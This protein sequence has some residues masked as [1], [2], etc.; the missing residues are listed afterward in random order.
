MSQAIKRCREGDV[1]AARQMIAEKCDENVE[2]DG[3]SPLSVEIEKG[4]RQLVSLLLDAE[5]TLQRPFTTLLQL[6]IASGS[7]DVAE[8]FISQVTEVTIREIIDAACGGHRSLVTLLLSKFT[9]QGGA[10]ILRLLPQVTNFDENPRHKA[11]VDLIVEECVAQVN[12]PDSDDWT[13]LQRAA[14]IGNAY[15]VSALIRTGADVN[16]AGGEVHHSALMIASQNG[17]LAVV[18]ALLDVGPALQIDARDAHGSTALHAAVEVSSLPVVEALLEARADVNA[19]NNENITPLF[20]ASSAAIA[21]ALLDAG[22]DANHRGKLGFAPVFATNS[23]R[24]V[25]ALANERDDVSAMMEIGETASVR[26]ADARN[27]ELPRLLPAIPAAASLLKEQG[28]ALSIA[29]QE[30]DPSF[31]AAMLR[32]G[33]NPNIADDG[34]PTP[35]MAACHVRIAGLLLDAGADVNARYKDGTTALMFAASDDNK[36]TSLVALLLERGADVNAS[37]EDGDNSIM[38]A[39]SKDRVD[40]LCRLLQAPAA[41]I[42]EQAS[43]G[44]TALI[45]AS[46]NGATAAVETLI[47]AGADVHL[48]TTTGHTALHYADN[49]NIARLLWS[50]GARDSLSNDSMTTL[51]SACINNKPDVVEFLLQCGLNVNAVHQNTTVLMQAAAQ[52]QLDVF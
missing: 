32:L 7:A 28:S 10:S 20:C 29:V 22:A 4:N 6:S 21:S 44:A 38:L 36:D 23:S 43:N 2:V 51:T 9:P 15:V 40:V 5:D 11:A 48:T 18:K 25:A 1:S 27:V 35:L 26:A 33:H 16:A 14:E 12:V 46:A 52:G 39:A 24:G 41:R 47:A 3:V 37:C 17:D 49:A 19:A 42:D 45:V 30:R 34:C 8:R 31:V 50:A 13:P